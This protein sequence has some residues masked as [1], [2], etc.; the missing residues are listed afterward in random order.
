MSV[1]VRKVFLAYAPRPGGRGIISFECLVF[2]FELGEGP[3]DVL[4]IIWFS[5]CHVARP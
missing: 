5:D 4:F 2:S 3:F 1:G